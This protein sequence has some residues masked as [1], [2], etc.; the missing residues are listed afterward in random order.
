[1]VKNGSLTDDPGGNYAKRVDMT[2]YVSDDDGETWKG[3]LLLKAG[4]CSYPDGD[5]GA[6]GTIYVTFDNDRYGRQD[7]FLAKFTEAEVRAGGTLKK[8]GKVKTE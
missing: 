5:Q 1:M 4:D 2:A 3:G 8:L 6:D 7:I